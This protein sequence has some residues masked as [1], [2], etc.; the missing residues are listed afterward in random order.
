M[1]AIPFIS[2]KML[3]SG[4]QKGTES[5]ALPVGGDQIVLLQQQRKESLS[6]VLGL[7]PVM[8]VPTNECVHRMP[9]GLTQRGQRLAGIG[10]R[11][12][13]RCLNKS[14]ARGLE[15]RRR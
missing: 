13:G 8:A 10:C 6:Q 9:V 11:A 12:D 5:A 1:F 3:N 15:S 14:P 2:E 7:I 4:Q